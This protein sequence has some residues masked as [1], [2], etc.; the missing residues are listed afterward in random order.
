MMRNDSKRLGDQKS[1][2]EDRGRKLSVC[3]LP[4]LSE[5]GGRTAAV[6]A[7]MIFSLVSISAMWVQAQTQD[8]TRD[9]DQSLIR[10]TAIDVFVDSGAHSLAAYQFEL[11]VE[12]GDAKIVGVEGGEHEAFKKPPYYDPKALHAEDRIIIAAYNTG[13]D[14]PTGKTRVARLHLQISGE[15]TPDYVVRLIVAASENGERLDATATV[16]EGK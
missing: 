16:A 2:M 4:T 14:L 5:G 15:L 8:E 3:G 7:V 9:A 6:L 13:D 11:T 12:K 1:E 10:F